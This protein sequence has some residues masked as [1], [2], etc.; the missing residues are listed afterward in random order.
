MAAQMRLHIS[1]FLNEL[2]IFND[3]L[4]LASSIEADDKLGYILLCT[5]PQPLW[6]VSD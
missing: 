2:G 4:A 1:A 3:Q 6:F 5:Q